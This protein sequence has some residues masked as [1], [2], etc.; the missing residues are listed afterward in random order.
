MVS[1]MWTLWVMDEKAQKRT[2]DK[3][4]FDAVMVWSRNGTQGK[5]GVGFKPLSVPK[6]RMLLLV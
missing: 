5:A 6:F 1:G 2:Q 4:E 3:G